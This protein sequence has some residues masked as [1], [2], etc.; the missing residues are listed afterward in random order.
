[1][2]HSVRLK[3]EI[4]LL[5]IGLLLLLAAVLGLF[6]WRDR[7][8]QSVLLE[9]NGVPVPVYDGEAA[10]EING[11]VPFFTSADMTGCPYLS[12]S[13]LDEYGRC[14]PAAGC[15]S[16]SL[17]PEVERESI[18]D[19]RPS[20]WRTIRYDDL[21]EGRYLYNRCHLIGYLLSGENANERN[22]ITGT[23]YMNT[24]GMLP[25]E[26]L[27]AQYMETT[28]NQVLYRV[29]PVFEGDHPIVT[30]VLME[31]RSVEDSGLGLSFC[32]F[33][34]NVQPGIEIDYATGD[35]RILPK[36]DIYNLFSG[37]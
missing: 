22:L 36:P 35:S 6:A 5:R 26:I 33:V 1:M 15:L 37:K 17:M 27:T 16:L 32:V 14:G 9:V 3:K 24:E 12:F 13:L 31:A 2:C 7:G 23:R 4:R 11:N 28:G 18:G 8:G 30:G 19:V 25:Y 21:I 20:G 10:V 34:Y 29:T